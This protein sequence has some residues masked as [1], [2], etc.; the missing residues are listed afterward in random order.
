MAK[1]KAKEKAEKKPVKAEG[2]EWSVK[3]ELALSCSCE[4]FCP[5]VVSLGQHPPTNGFCHAWIAARIDKGH[6]GDVKLNGLN[7]CMLV[8]IPGKMGAGNWTV[9]LYIDEKADDAQF[10][11]MEK[12][13]SGGA[14]GTTGLFRMLVGSYLGARR[15]AVTYDT[16]GEMRT[17]TAGK[18]VFG[19]VA[20]IT[21]A[22][23][24]KAV[25]IENTSYWMGPSV[26]IAQARKS[27]IRDFGR[28]WNFDG[29]SAEICAI[30]WAG[31]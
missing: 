18:S 31:P 6:F 4:L 23:P 17:I 7:I 24:E 5:C 15:E 10:A 2:V 11:A 13:F 12:I 20:P 22:D 14:R 3:G 28:V 9:A 1:K 26:V 29:G 21:G 8:D 19:E 30:E 25:S 16:E 27:K